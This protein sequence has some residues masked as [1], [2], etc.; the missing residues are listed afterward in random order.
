[1]RSPSLGNRCEKA[2]PDSLQLHQAIEILDIQ[3]CPV[4]N[5]LSKE[6]QQQ[7]RLKLKYTVEFTPFSSSV[8][9]ILRENL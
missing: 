2:A 5:S 1:M 3:R 8:K 9:L 4:E 6:R 7:L